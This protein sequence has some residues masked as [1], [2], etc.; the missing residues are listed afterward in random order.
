[1][2][3]QQH[4]SRIFLCLWV[5]FAHFFPVLIFLKG[6][7]II[8]ICWIVRGGVRGCLSATNQFVGWLRRF[9][10]LLLVG[11][12]RR[13]DHPRN[14]NAIAN[15]YH[16]LIR[17]AHQS[18]LLVQMIRLLLV[19]GKLTSLASKICKAFCRSSS[20]DAHLWETISSYVHLL[21]ILCL[22]FAIF[23]QIWRV[24]LKKTALRLLQYAAA[25]FC[26][27]TNF[28]CQLFCAFLCHDLCASSK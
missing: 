14:F 8:I 9:G 5:K 3:T 18:Q 25:S 11:G 20:N 15:I 16:E 13:S 2:S 21:G 10:K 17:G 19:K 7:N 4:C 6:Q 1:M 28:I 23:L 24:R 26:W 22:K 27:V 12:R